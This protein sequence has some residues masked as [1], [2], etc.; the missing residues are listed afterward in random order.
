MAT[1]KESLDYFGKF[2]MENHRDKIL[3]T[4]EKA[5]AGNW[6]VPSFQSFQ[7]VFTSL[8][9]DHLFLLHQIH[10]LPNEFD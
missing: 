10:Q 6:K 8:S 2:L 7:D 5:F 4:L 9:Q 3:L 1:E